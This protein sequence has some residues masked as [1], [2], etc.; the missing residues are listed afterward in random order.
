MQVRKFGKLSLGELSVWLVVSR[1]NATR[2]V[3]TIFIS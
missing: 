3:I 1:D 2:W